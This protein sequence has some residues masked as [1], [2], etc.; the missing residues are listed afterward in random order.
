[1]AGDKAHRNEPAADASIR[2]RSV[3][4][5]QTVPTEATVWPPILYHYCDAVGLLGILKPSWPKGTQGPQGGAALLRAS[6]VRY[7]ND[8]R[9]LRHGLELLRERLRAEV[10]TDFE[11]SD[12][13]AVFDLLANRLD[14]PLFDESAEHLRVFAACFCKKGDLLSQWR[15]YAGGIG[16]YAIGFRTEVLKDRATALQLAPP[17]SGQFVFPPTLQPV[18]YG[19]ENAAPALSQ[20]VAGIR[21][22]WE[23]GYLVATDGGASFG[24]VSGFVYGLLAQL[25]DDAFEEEHEYRLLGFLELGELVSVRSRATGLV[26]YLEFGVN[27]PQNGVQAPAAVAEIIVGP[28]SDQK[29]QIMAVRDLLKGAGF[30]DVEVKPSKAPYRG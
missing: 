15:G 2:D 9:E 28:G 5:A 30:S 3:N 14:V 1:M 11:S 16:G 27:M 17:T 21:A 8:S 6:D 19:Q 20:L 29:G 10:G 18:I 22:G 25:K 12:V 26:P 24:W 23:S 7:M 4:T 13:D